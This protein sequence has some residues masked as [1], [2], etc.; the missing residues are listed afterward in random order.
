MSTSDRN[1]LN[2]LGEHYKDTMVGQT[3]PVKMEALCDYLRG[4]PSLDFSEK[5]HATVCNHLQVTADELAEAMA[6]LQARSSQPTPALLRTIGAAVYR[7][8]KTKE[9]GCSC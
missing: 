4:L 2:V 9:G 1:A 8:N 7:T 6:A 5:E 3:N